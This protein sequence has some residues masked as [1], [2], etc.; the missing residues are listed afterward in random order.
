MDLHHL[1][2]FIAVA[3]ELSFRRAAERLHL[4]RPPLTRQ[5]KA[6]EK[7]VG[8]LLLVR[9][10]R[11]AIR[12]TDAGHAFLKHAKQAL[13]KVQ[14]AGDQARQA[15][16]GAGG[17]LRL[18]G[19]RVHSPAA[20][21]VYL[22]EFRR[23]YPAVG[24]TFKA[25][26]RSE[27]F[28]ALRDGSIHLSIS[29]DFGEALEPSLESKVIADLHLGVVLP[30]EHPLA[31]QRGTQ[32]DLQALGKEV[33]LQPVPEEKPVYFGLLDEAW[34]R[35]VSTPRVVHTVDGPENV[36]AMVAAGYGV[37]VLSGNSADA[38]NLGCRVKRLRL[39]SPSYRL[40]MLW[41]KG[42]SSSVLLNFLKLSDQ[43]SLPNSDF[44]SRPR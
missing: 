19:C 4:S 41:L 40:R 21:N 37:T 3:E 10:G 31:R 7:E 23:C 6:L 30:A 28:M 42:T 11:R 38:A 15:A 22:P 33:F 29:A 25:T 44:M 24:V 17:F 14:A 1:H 32:L 35:T 5:I 16:Q 20:L 8:V 9:D 12:L 43:L 2:Y 36:L 39:P 26:N 27:E 34:A 13:Q 18:A